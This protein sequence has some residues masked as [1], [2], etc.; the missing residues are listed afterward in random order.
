MFHVLPGDLHKVGNFSVSKNRK[1]LPV[2]H[3]IFFFISAFL[4]E[5]DDLSETKI[6][7]QRFSDNDNNW[8]FLCN[9]LRVNKPKLTPQFSLRLSVWHLAPSL[10]CQL[11]PGIEMGSLNYP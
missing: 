5:R 7:D 6:Q 11:S 9:Y 4:L 3:F 2:R 1:F 10:P 8:L